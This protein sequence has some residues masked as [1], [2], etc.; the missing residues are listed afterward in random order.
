M[1]NKSKD[2]DIYGLLSIRTVSA[3]MCPLEGLCEQQLTLH[4]LAFLIEHECP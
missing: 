3:L 2:G 4:K 1:V